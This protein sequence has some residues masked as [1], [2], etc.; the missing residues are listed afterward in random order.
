MHRKLHFNYSEI[1]KIIP[2]DSSVLD[3]GCGN[4]ELM[5]L[6][7]KKKNAQT[8]GVDIEEGMVIQC[9]KQGLSV[10]QGNLDEGLKDYTTASYDF[11][12]L[13]ETL[14][15]IRNPVL[16]LQEMLRVGKHAIVSFPNFGFIHNR[17]QLFFTGKMP[18]N[19]QLP[20]EWY[21]TPNIHFCTQKDF[22]NLCKNL[23]IRITKE[24]ALW[25]NKIQIPVF[26]NLLSSDVC[27]ILE[28][29]NHNERDSR[30]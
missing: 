2:Y 14:Q 3:L 25:Q 17:L 19:K 9:I 1:E 13:N 5:A 29:E 11:V 6:L 18:V 4:G 28:R 7:K 26:R 22:R 16:V 21:N 12:I 23:N 27:Y 15:V 10:F 8:R 30:S 24:I 20:F